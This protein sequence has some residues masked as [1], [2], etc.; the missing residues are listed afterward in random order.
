MERNLADLNE[1]GTRDHE[2]LK[3]VVISAVRRQHQNVPSRDGELR[4]E[5]EKFKILPV[6]IDKTDRSCCPLFPRHPSDGG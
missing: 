4:C 3:A 1:C 6:R 2:I 5:L